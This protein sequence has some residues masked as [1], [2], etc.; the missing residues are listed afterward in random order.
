MLSS[1]KLTF[2]QNNVAIVIDGAFSVM[3][4]IKCMWIPKYHTGHQQ[5]HNFKLNI[6]NRGPTVNILQTIL[7]LQY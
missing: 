4:A 2:Y 3:I 6:R 5:S 1:T 7:I